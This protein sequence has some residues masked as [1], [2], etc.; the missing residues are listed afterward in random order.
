[1]IMKANDFQTPVGLVSG[2]ESPIDQI[3]DWRPNVTQVREAIFKGHVVGSHLGIDV[4]P[5]E[6]IERLAPTQDDVELFA[7]ACHDAV[8]GGRLIDF[9]DWTN[10]VIK[11]AANRGGPLYGRGAIGHPFAKPYVFLHTWEEA[12]SV[13]LVNPLEPDRLAGGDCECVE[14]SPASI[15][16]EKVL[17]IGDRIFLQPPPADAPHTVIN[18]YKKYHCSAI[19]SLWRYMPGA[20][21]I[22]LQAPPNAAAGNVLDP[23]MTA[24]LIL[25]TRGIARETVSASEKLQKARRKSGKPPIP[26]Y[27]R[28][29]SAPYITAIQAKRARGHGGP[30][31][32]SHASPIGHI[33]M[34]HLRTYASGVQVFVRDALVNMSEDAKRAWLTGS[35]SHYVVKS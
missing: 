22:N 27:D 33:R 8:R 19:P 15:A 2:I 7:E 26:S 11:H 32:G 21:A 25:S 6:L 12:T 31:G 28:V 30:L 16:G 34:G 9:G 20:E 29:F 4:L 35:R 17:M 3:A 13:Y 24:L 18:D 14:L 1:M 23:L 5:R 10:D